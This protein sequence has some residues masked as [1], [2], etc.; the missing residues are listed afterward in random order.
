MFKFLMFLSFI[1]IIGCIEDQNSTVINRPDSSYF[2]VQQDISEDSLQPVS[3]S[4]F[5]KSEEGGEITLDDEAKVTIPAGAL[6]QDA[7]IVFSRL[8]CDGYFRHQAFAGC[9]YDVKAENTSLAKE[10]QVQL[11]VKKLDAQCIS[12]N[13]EE[14]FRCQIDS[15]IS[16]NSVLGS[17]AEF[18]NFTL[19]ATKKFNGITPNYMSDILLQ[20][21]GGDIFGEW[22]LLYFIGSDFH[23]IGVEFTPSTKYDSCEPYSRFETR[24][25]NLLE[26]LSITPVEGE[27]YANFTWYREYTGYEVEITTL[28]CLESVGD[29][30]TPNGVCSIEDDFCN[31]VKP[32]YS[33]GSGD[34]PLYEVAGGISFYNDGE[35]IVYC[36][37]E[38]TLF[39]YQG[40]GDQSALSI[41]KRR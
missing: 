18:T 33:S 9:L 3:V 23:I 20:N 11:P 37:N 30:C 10:Y 41:Y 25:F 4:V 32:I 12:S 29:E 15:L 35:P 26:N 7:T 34:T 24:T 1:F 8:T 38:D 19:N 31:C 17:A 28:N 22:E 21:C 36:V 40:T 27:S 6:T 14:G 2:D 16:D 39:W 5:I 13:S